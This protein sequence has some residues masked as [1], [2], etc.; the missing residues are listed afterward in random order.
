MT[1]LRFGLFLAQ[2]VSGD[3]SVF[4]DQAVAENCRPLQLPHDRLGEFLKCVGQN[5]H[6]GQR[7]QFAQKLQRAGQRTSVAMTFWMSASFK[8]CWSRISMRPP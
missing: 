3:P 6:L 7:A 2:F 4:H 1:A 8:P 5:N